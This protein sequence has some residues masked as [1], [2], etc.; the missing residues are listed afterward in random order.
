MLDHRKIDKAFQYSISKIQQ[1]FKMSSYSE[2]QKRKM[3]HFY[4]LISH[5]F[6]ILA[7][8]FLVIL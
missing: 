3:L 4:D 8:C 2:V 5:R 6:T 7:I 1:I